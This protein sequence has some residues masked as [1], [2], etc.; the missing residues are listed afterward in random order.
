M[1][2]LITLLRTALYPYQHA[3]ASGKWRAVDG[4]Y[5]T[6]SSY[7][8]NLVP[9]DINGTT[10]DAFVHDRKTG[11]TTLISVDSAGEQGNSYSF[12]S[13]ISADGRYVAFF[14]DADNLV[15]GDPNGTYDVFVRDRLL[16]TSKSADLQLAVTSQPDSVQNGQVAEYLFTISNNG[17]DSVGAVTLIDTV[18]GGKG[19]LTPSQGDCTIAAVR[20]CR[21]R[22]LAV[23]ASA[24][25][26]AA[27]EA[28]DPLTQ[29]LSVSAAPVDSEPAN[30]SVTVATPV[31]P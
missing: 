23:G 13:S 16:K 19:S 9:R 25:V 20:V 2:A 30:S 8:D 15:P 27:F 31:T 18:S 21:L 14:S 10:T 29:H 12:A 17:P 11:A 4:R 7:A 1:R 24:T 28:K 6:F 26:S 5:V 3:E 22:A